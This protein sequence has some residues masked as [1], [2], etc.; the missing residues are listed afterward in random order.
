ML[1]ITARL[2]RIL[3]RAVRRFSGKSTVVDAIED[4]FEI[5]IGETVSLV[6][7][8]YQIS[9]GH[10]LPVSIRSGFSR[11]LGMASTTFSSSL[12]K[13]EED[14]EAVEVLEQ[15][16]QSELVT[17][18]LSKLLEPGVEEFNIILL[19]EH[20]FSSVEPEISDQFS[21]SQVEAAWRDF[22]KAFSFSS[23]SMPELREFIRASYEEGSFNALTDIKDIVDRMESDAKNFIAQEE[24]LTGSIDDY[25]AELSDYKSWAEERIKKYDTERMQ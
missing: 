10:E 11:C 21:R 24:E 5:S 7:D 9:G 3:G 14:T 15:Y 20:F 4:I 13:N 6:N 18:E 19:S 22:Q 23:R 25:E 1:D 8:R 2:V 16:F 12:F 17:K